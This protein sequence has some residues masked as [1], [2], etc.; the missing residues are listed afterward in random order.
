[1]DQAEV[2]KTARVPEGWQSYLDEWSVLFRLYDSVH[3]VPLS[4]MDAIATQIRALADA[5]DE[6]GR[7]SILNALQTLQYQLEPPNDI[8]LRLYNS[9][10]FSPNLKG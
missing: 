6:A 3:L 7:Y 5:A 4:N 8:F 1:M 9:V 2:Y 10:C